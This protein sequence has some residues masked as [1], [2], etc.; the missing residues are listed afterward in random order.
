MPEKHYIW[1]VFPVERSW[2]QKIWSRHYAIS[3]TVFKVSCVFCF[4]TGFFYVAFHLPIG[5]LQWG[6]KRNVHIPSQ[7]W[8]FSRW[9]FHPPRIILFHSFAL[10]KAQVFIWKNHLIYLMPRLHGDGQKKR[11]LYVAIFCN[12]QDP[13]GL[14][15]CV[16]LDGPLASGA[17]KKTRFSGIMS[18][19]RTSTHNFGN[20]A[21]KVF[22]VET[23]SI[24][25]RNKNHRRKGVVPNNISCRRVDCWDVS[26]RSFLVRD[27][28]KPSLATGSLW[29]VTR[30][31]GWLP[32]ADFF[33]RESIFCII[34]CDA[35]VT[36]GIRGGLI[37]GYGK[38]NYCT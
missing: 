13:P 23:R 29:G 3:G 10:S 38:Q 18:K 14:L 1:S 34:H 28:Y 17:R 21:V 33:C 5:L 6:C 16:S 37:E 20:Q 26:H 11:L 30:I 31:P 7:V 22:S 35:L 15:I 12:H 24:S 8:Y 36:L 4:M 9:I 32:T 2:N 27:P 19:N 25:V